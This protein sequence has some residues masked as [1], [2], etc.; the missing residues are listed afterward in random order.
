MRTFSAGI[1][2][3]LVLLCGAVFAAGPVVTPL[4]PLAD[5]DTYSG[6]DKADRTLT[7]RDCGRPSVAWITYYRSDADLKTPRATLTLY[8]KRIHSAG[9]LAVC[10][11][12]QSLER[13]RG[14]HDS[15]FIY[16]TEKPVAVL[17][18][19]HDCGDSLLS[20]DVSSAV[21]SDGFQGLAL[22]GRK[23]LM[24]VFSSR[25]AQFPPLILLSYDLPGGSLAW[26]SGSGNPDEKI[27]KIGD[28]YVD[29]NTSDVLQ[30][31][32]T[33]WVWA[34]NLIGP[35]GPRGPQ[36]EKGDLG[37]QGIAGPAG[38]Q[39]EIGP[40]GPTGPQGP[41]GEKGDPGPQGMA[42]PEGPQG[43]K[44][45]KG[46]KGDQGIQGI[47]GPAGPQ[48]EIGPAGATGPQGLQGEKG[49]LGPQG[50][51]GRTGPQGVAGPAGATGP[52][53]PQG[54]PGPAGPQGLTGATG[55][56][57]LQGLAGQI[58]PQGLPGHSP[59]SSSRSV[60]SIASSGTV[61]LVLEGNRNAFDK[62]QRL[63]IS[64]TSTPA[65]FMEGTITDY[66]SSTG[67]ATVLLDYSEGS[68]VSLSHWNILSAGVPGRGQVSESARTKIDRIALLLDR[69]DIAASFPA[70]AFESACAWPCSTFMVTLLSGG[71]SLG[72]VIGFMGNEGIS[73]P[74]RLT[75]AVETAVA[76]N[77][78]AYLDQQGVVE[79][80]RGKSSSYFA[81]IIT[82]MGQIGRAHV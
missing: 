54:V 46:E 11:I 6:S 22:I 1:C 7:V 38:P 31:I 62:G 34:F 55:A 75:V 29:L 13:T 35:T 28:L 64:V 32:E 25:E 53:G 30:K 74:Y 73:T 77:P 56:Q 19:T 61:T 80:L 63:R 70:A 52:Q 66:S 5:G 15:S 68:G 43:P 76:L 33:G 37:I 79:F 67:T 51:I 45:D 71:T 60:L 59:I 10:R 58:G 39:G 57:G 9:E 40:A 72:S 18:F 49:D 78:A 4:F 3:A 41:Q 65:N 48:G 17:P 82:S 69:E 16:D 81:G 23:G 2:F 20:I 27:G 42:G 26:Y 47:A 8:L 44:G 50:V 21:R 14:K 24:A 36:G 12:R